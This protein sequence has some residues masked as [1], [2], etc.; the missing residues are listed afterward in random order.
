LGDFEKFGGHPQFPRQESSPAPLIVD[1]GEVE[2]GGSDLVG[3]IISL[4]LEGR[5]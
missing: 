2:G 1:V 3:Y 4:S 5:G